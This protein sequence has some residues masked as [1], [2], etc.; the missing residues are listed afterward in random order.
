MQIK[1]IKITNY[2]CIRDLEFVPSNH[3]VI[4]GQVNVGKS[5]LLN[6]LALVLDPDVGRRYKPIDEADFFEGRIR[7]N[8]GKPLS[9][10]IEVTL[11]Y[12]LQ[13]E[14]NYF[15][16]ETELWDE[17]DQK[18]IEDSGN[19]AVLDDPRNLFALR[20]GFEAKFDE[21]EKDVVYRWFYP[22]YSSDDPQG[23][24]ICS[25]SE[26]EKVGFFLIPAERNVDKALSFTRYS[27]L[28]KALR[29]DKIVLDEEL[30][31][32]VEHTRGAGN[33]LFDN[34]DF[35]KLIKEIELR[36]EVMLALDPNASRKLSFEVSELGH[37][38]V[39]NILKAFVLPQGSSRPYPVANQG[40]GARQIITLA[41][42]RMLAA[43]KGSCIIAI[44]EP[45][46]SL[47]PDMQRS[48]ASDLVRSHRQTFITTHSVHIAQAIEQKHLFLM[49]AGKEEPSQVRP[50]LP[51]PSRNL[52]AGTIKSVRRVRAYHPS[53]FLDCLFS[54][55]VLLVEGPTDREAVPVLIRK[56]SASPGRPFD[57]D[58]LS[59]GVFP[60]DSKAE[61]SKIAPYFKA[62]GKPVYGLADREK[63]S[64][65]EDTK[66]ERECDC[67]LFWPA[68]TAIEKVLLMKIT[69]ETAANY[70]ADVTDMGETYFQDSRTSEKGFDGQKADIVGFLKKRLAHRQFA[71]FIPHSE[72]SDLI[73]VLIDKL[74]LICSGQ[75]SSRRVNLDAKAD[76]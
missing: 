19:I 71:E 60:C 68:G 9:I 74:T 55:R 56:V 7:D 35:E 8:E 46:I 54:S 15:L 59:I 50:T 10:Q 61:I 40:M 13:E 18:I 64:A 26:R 62:L 43:R 76:S 37:Y 63:G 41:T 17:R 29:A 22:K 73:V 27:A 51:S 34:E 32:I 53:D 39:M 70:I 31:K 38:D 44:E 1:R 65:S 42:L 57:L 75:C 14:H 28:D 4:I 5:T 30:G 49:T 12:E 66:I 69:A 45:E 72:I 23:Q 2:R 21:K 25:R 11:V 36:V 67:V 58:G 16:D 20:I 3:N 52:S 48:L 33:H 6:A 24:R 47:H